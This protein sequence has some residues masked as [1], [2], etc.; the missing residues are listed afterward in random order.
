M[1]INSAESKRWENGIDIL[2]DYLW[3]PV[4]E[5]P[6]V[7]HRETATLVVSIYPEELK[8]GGTINPIHNPLDVFRVDFTS[9]QWTREGEDLAAFGKV[10]QIESQHR[11]RFYVI[12]GQGFVKLEV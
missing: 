8:I 4:I 1:T 3:H 6:R 9:E 5:Y 10:S 2:N 11:L 12:D 7:Q